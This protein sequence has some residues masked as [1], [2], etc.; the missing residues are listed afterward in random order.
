MVLADGF[1]S[2]PALSDLR[3]RLYFLLGTKRLAYSLSGE[4]DFWGWEK[5]EL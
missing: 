4:L 1:C 2:I 5:S 3:S